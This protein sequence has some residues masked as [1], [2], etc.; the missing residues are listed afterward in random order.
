M[1]QLV[2]FTDLCSDI[3]IKRNKVEDKKSEKKED[4]LSSM[5]P[6]AR[7]KKM[8]LLVKESVRSGAAD[9]N[10]YYGTRKSGVWF[11]EAPGVCSSC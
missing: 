2:D 11:P 6:F 10:P 5:N 3:P 7:P 9:N 4:W 8:S 1:I